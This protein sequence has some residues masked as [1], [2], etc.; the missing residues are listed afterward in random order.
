MGCGSILMPPAAKPSIM[1]LLRLMRGH[2]ARLGVRDVHA[3]ERDIRQLY[4]AMEARLHRPPSCAT[5]R[6]T[7]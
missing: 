7:P 5:L 3:W 4:F 6:A 2:K 1:Q